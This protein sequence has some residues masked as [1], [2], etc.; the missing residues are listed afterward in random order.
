MD[1]PNLPLT[2]L[3]AFEV[4]ARQGSFT[5]AA[6]E[7]CVTQAAVSHQVIALESLLGV[8]LLKRTPSGLILTDEG[9]ALL[10]VLT[11]SFDRIGQVLDR[12]SGGAYRE[13]LNVG[14]VTTFAV[15]WLLPRMDG[16]A[17]LHPGIDLRISTNNNRVD[18]AREG[19]DMAIRFGDGTWPGLAAVPLLDAALT[20]LCAPATAARLT[21]PEDLA[22]EVLLR[23][24]R[25]AEW[26]LW[27]SALKLP[28]PDLRGPVLDS[29]VALAELAA[30]GR[31]VALLPPL[32]F[33][34]RLATGRLVR[35][36]P[37]EVATGRY[38][39][40]APRSRKR[41][42]GMERF[43]A[44]LLDAAN[45]PDDAEGTPG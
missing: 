19:L 26:P 13:T 42:P 43:E 3:R 39:L 36:F 11:Q 30:E 29:S 16:F 8:R 6:I 4:A 22:D 40:T 15:G 10:P 37:A 18:L 2:A 33:G 5:R 9:T 1:R 23:S 38:W 32:M 31:G 7:L 21:R 17:R 27:F 12:F 14:V 41:T 45:A 20:P 35:P 24:Y 25:S 28:C 44:W 34:D